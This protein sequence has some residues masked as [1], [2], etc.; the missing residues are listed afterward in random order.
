MSDLDAVLLEN[1][2][3]TLAETAGIGLEQFQYLPEYDAYYHTHGDT[4]YF[5]S[6]RIVAGERS[7]DTFRLYY[8]DNYARYTD[9]DWLCVTLERQS[10]G[11]FWFVSNQPS[12]KPAIPTVY[13]EGDPVLTIPLTDLAAY[14]PAPAPVERRAND[15]AEGEGGLGIEAEDGSQ[16]S[17]STYL[18]TDGN[19][20]AAVIYDRAAGNRGMS[21]WD[22]GCFF[23][24]PESNDF[25]YGSRTVS[26]GF[27]SD[28]F[29]HDGVVVSY[30]APDP[31]EAYERCM[32][33]FVG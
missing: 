17:V 23:T 26:L 8:P 3:L 25:T 31:V 14:E 12:E 33:E 29:G 16:V 28:L 21:V 1:T 32:A 5:H 27:F 6:V 4:N 22:V 20:Y 15:C 2:G 9:C 13:P 18:S 30:S 7:G 11:S 24:F 10:D 19:I